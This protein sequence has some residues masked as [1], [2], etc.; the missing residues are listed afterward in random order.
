MSVF[1]PPI[2]FA[3]LVEMAESFSTQF[4]RIRP[5]AEAMQYVM[6]A[7]LIRTYIGDEWCDRN[8]SG[9]DQSDPY[10]AQN[11]S[12]NRALIMAQAKITS[13][14]EM[15]FNLQHIPNARERFARIRDSSLEVAIS[16]LEAARL[17]A[18]SEQRFKFIEEQN[19][20]GFDYDIEVTLDDETPLCC[21][22]KCKLESTELSKETILNSLR[23][24]AR[25]VPDD[26]PGAIFIKFPES[27]I[28]SPNITT[29][30]SDALHGLFERSGRIVEVVVHWEEWH[31]LETGQLLRL[32]KFREE[33]NSN[34]RFSAKKLAPILRA[35]S[36]LWKPSR[37][38]SFAEAIHAAQ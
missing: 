14:G 18:L 25:Q 36:P 29:I 21:E 4:P 35:Q 22:S 1:L 7:T 31:E 34:S 20:K 12:A 8:L 38:K 37:W 28:R 26:K 2:R 15:I 11:F 19:R 3:D 23:K 27:W 16:D 17:L 10:I 24:A 6:A 13:I 32:A 33:L 9:S 5:S 30:L